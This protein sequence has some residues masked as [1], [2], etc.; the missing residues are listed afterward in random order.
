MKSNLRILLIDDDKAFIDAIAFQLRE[1]CKHKTIVVY[2]AVD[3]AETLESTTSGVDVILVDYEMPE[4]NGLEFLQWMKTGR[5]ETPVI[6][7]T[8]Y[9]SGTV[10]EQAMKLGAYDYIRKD[11]LDLNILTH[12]IDATHERHLYH[13]DQQFEAER[14]REMGLDSQATDRARDVL[15]TITPP[16]NTALA[17]IN[18]ELEVKSEDVLRE[19]TP[20]TREKVKLIVESILKE[21]RVLE[22]SVRGLL[23]LYRILY[24]HHTEQREIDEIKKELEKSLKSGP[25]L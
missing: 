5:R 4:M 25:G 2:S 3:A 12:A 13:I 24:A 6:M 18:Y 23:T 20:T 9:D 15:S 8:A 7:L 22:T 11:K 17:N 21:V 16:L 1:E 10:A 19:L 14:L